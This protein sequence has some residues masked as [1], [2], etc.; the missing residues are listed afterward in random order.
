MGNLQFPTRKKL[1]IYV[2]YGLSKLTVYCGRGLGYCGRMLF[3]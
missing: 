3:V 1:Y 2:V